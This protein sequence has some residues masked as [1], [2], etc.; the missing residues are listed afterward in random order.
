MRIAIAGATGRIGRLTQEVL[1]QQGHQVVPISRRQG[2]DVTSGDGLGRALAG[3]DAVIDTLNTRPGTEQAM[4]DFFGSTT[5]NL[6]QAEQAAGVGH[7]VLLSIASME[8]VPENAHYA[9]KRAQESA[10]EQGPVPYSIVPATQFH[11]FPAMIAGATIRDGVA[12]VPPLTLQPIAPADVAAVLARI[13]VEGPQRRHRAIAGPRPE[14][15]VSMAQRTLAARGQEV[16]VV[17]GWRGGI[18]S[19]SLARDD[20]LAPADAELAPTTFDAWLAA[21]AG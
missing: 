16:E 5:R 15:M 1:E 3:V 10:I 11:D 4:I 9:G 8:K 17:G 21:E 6:L 2:V 14:E 19:P 20:L 13:A 18:F 7:H 12:E